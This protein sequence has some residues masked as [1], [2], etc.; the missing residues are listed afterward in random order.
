ML[1]EGSDRPVQRFDA[2][3]NELLPDKFGV[4]DGVPKR[5]PGLL[6]PGISAGTLAPTRWFGKVVWF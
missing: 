5:A 6:D 1:D 4:D 2:E 3:F